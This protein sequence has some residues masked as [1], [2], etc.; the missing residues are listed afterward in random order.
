M[1][2]ERLKKI[3]ICTTTTTKK[4]PLSRN[5]TLENI[6]FATIKKDFFLQKEKEWY[7]FDISETGIRVVQ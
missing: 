4:L 1:C 3:S 5:N 6:F 7:L 2:L